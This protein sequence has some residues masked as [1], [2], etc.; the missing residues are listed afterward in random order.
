MSKTIFVTGAA[1]G[2]GKATALLFGSKGWRVGCYDVDVEG[3]RTVAAQLE[4][5]AHGGADVAGT[6]GGL[7]VLFNCAG[8]LRMGRFEDVSAAECQKQLDVN[9]MGVILG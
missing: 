3:A 5:A 9:V 7:D 4:G 2:I 1:S 6:S 8:I